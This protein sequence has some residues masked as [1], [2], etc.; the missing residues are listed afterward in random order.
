MEIIHCEKTEK[1]GKSFIAM[2][3]NIKENE[4]PLIEVPKG[5]KS[6]RSRNNT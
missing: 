5:G 6:E 4:I 3:H 2:W 1:Q